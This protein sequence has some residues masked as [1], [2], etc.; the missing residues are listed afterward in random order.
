MSASARIV[1]A[2]IDGAI[3]LWTIDG[4][5]STIFKGHKSAVWRVAFRGCLKNLVVGSKKF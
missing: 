2:G 4:K 3:R 1:P 5:L